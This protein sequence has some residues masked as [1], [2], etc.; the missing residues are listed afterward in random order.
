MA[1]GSS[2]GLAEAV[3]TNP[4]LYVLAVDRDVT[5]LEQLKLPPRRF[6]TWKADIGLAD[7]RVPAP[8]GD[9]VAAALAGFDLTA[10]LRLL[11]GGPDR[12]HLVV[13]KKAVHELPRRLQPAFLRSCHDVLVPGGRFILFADAPESISAADSA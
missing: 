4:Q 2:N 13:A 1:G 8:G 12:A 6:R 9:G 7:T 3:R 5:Q 11:T 10:E